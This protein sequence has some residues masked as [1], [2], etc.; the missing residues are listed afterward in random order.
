MTQSW[1]Q[2]VTHYDAV[3]LEN[4]RL[5]KRILELEFSRIED[6][7]VESK[8]NLYLQAITKVYLVTKEE[9]RSPSR[10]A[11]LTE[12]RQVLYYL[13]TKDCAMTQHQI[14]RFLN[15]D[16]STVCHGI[17]TARLRYQHKIEEVR[18]SMR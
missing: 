7:S 12:A 4:Q 18:R 8:R 15:R 11:I 3:Q 6:D 2:K 16:H 1:Y 13:L 9:L 5:R 14:G 17:E 10:I